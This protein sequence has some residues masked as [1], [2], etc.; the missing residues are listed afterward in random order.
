[1]TLETGNAVASTRTLLGLYFRFRFNRFMRCPVKT[2]LRPPWIPRFCAAYGM[3]FMLPLSPS[4]PA[5]LM[6]QYYEARPGLEVLQ[7]QTD[8]F[9]QD[10][11]ERQHQVLPAENWVEE[12]YEG[13]LLQAVL[14]FQ[15]SI[16]WLSSQQLLSLWRKPLH[17]PLSDVQGTL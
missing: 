6:L 17:V 16:R 3:S 7:Q 5:E 4:S 10:F 14:E 13:C 2:T 15:C 9:I 8:K 12:G 1:M 11:E